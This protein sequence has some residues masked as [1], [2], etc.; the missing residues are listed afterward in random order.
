MNKELI[1]DVCDNY[2]DERLIDAVRDVLKEQNEELKQEFK[3]DFIEDHPVYFMI[4]RGV[5][6][7]SLG[8]TLFIIAAIS[9]IFISYKIDMAKINEQ[10]KICKE[11]GYGCTSNTI[12]H[13]IKY[14]NT[15][16]IEVK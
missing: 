11:T 7:A 14:D 13:D 8:F 2:M 16:L 6:W 15:P 4:T 12:N 9:S 3:N 10:A 1:Y 5:L